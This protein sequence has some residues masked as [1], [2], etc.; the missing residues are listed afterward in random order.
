MR[1][2]KGE[3]VKGVII[4]GSGMCTGGRVIGYLKRNISNPNASVI[5]IGYQVVGTLGREILENKGTVM[6]DGEEYPVKARILSISGFSAHG[7]Q[8]DLI[9]WAGSYDRDR[10][11]RVF[12]THG[13]IESSLELERLLKEKYE[14]R[15]HIPTLGESVELD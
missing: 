6:I 4:A 12:I 10:L 8:N 15:T 11:K 7:D 14:I 2:K 5:F 3:Q 9:N 1:G 13:E